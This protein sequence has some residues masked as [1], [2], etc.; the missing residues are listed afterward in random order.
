MYSQVEEVKL[1]YI[2][3]QHI[4]PGKGGGAGF[5]ELLVVPVSESGWNSQDQGEDN[6]ARARKAGPHPQCPELG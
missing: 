3:A 5:G 4:I 1:D 6:G 2:S